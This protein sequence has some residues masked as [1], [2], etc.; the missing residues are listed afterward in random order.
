MVG[1]TRLRRAIWRKRR[2]LKRET[3]LTKTKESAETEKAPK[4]TQSKHFNESSI[5]KQENPEKVLTSF[6]LDL[7]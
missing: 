1:D 3:H 7:Y 6:F 4:Q 5:A 2:A